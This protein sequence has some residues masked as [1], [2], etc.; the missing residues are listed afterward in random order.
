MAAKLQSLHRWF[1]EAQEGNGASVL[2]FPDQYLEPTIAMANA[3]FNEAAKDFPA[4]E[5]SAVVIYRLGGGTYG[6]IYAIEFK[7][8]DKQVCVAKGYKKV[9]DFPPVR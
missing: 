2:V 5:Q 3:L 9:P 1:K 8:P 7:V 6:N 4:L